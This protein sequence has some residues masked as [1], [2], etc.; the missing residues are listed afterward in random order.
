MGEYSEDSSKKK[1]KTYFHHR[2]LSNDCI[3]FIMEK[4][5]TGFNLSHVK[6]ADPGDCILL[7]DNCGSFPLCF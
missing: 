4:L 5:L 3:K 6:I 2:E 1:R 7:V